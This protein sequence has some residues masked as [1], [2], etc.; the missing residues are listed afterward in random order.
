M[1]RSSDEMESRTDDAGRVSGGAVTRRRFVKAGAGLLGA[2]GVTAIGLGAA[3]IGGVSGAQDGATPMATPMGD[4]DV[5]GDG[6]IEP[7]VLSSADGFLAVKLE[8]APDAAAGPGRVAY[9][10][11]VP[12][13]TLRVR[14]GDQLEIALV[15]SLGGDVTNLHV[16]GMHVSPKDNSDNIFLHVASGQTFAYSYAIPADHPPGLYWYHPH[17]HGDSSQQVSGGLA[18]AI[19]VEGALDDLPEIAGPDG[20]VARLQGSVPGSGPPAAV[21]G[22]RARS[23]RRSRSGRARHQRW[24]IL[25]A[26]ANAF[27]NL[28]I[29]A[30]PV[31]R[32]RDGRQPAAGAETSRSSSWDRRSGARC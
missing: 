12:G 27:F 25:N 10:Q 9:E 17:S 28:G 4:V 2:G 14:Q 8:A 31:P 1:M 26:S 24:R 32:D 20:A 16:H 29:G 23:T 18:G 21:P 11:S 22:Q 7:Y 6:F 3:G 19:I 30:A 15:N 5:D 13:P